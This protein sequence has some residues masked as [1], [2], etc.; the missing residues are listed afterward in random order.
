MSKHAGTQPPFMIKGLIVI[1]AIM[2]C[3]GLP[4][5][6]ETLEIVTEEAKVDPA[7]LERLFEITEMHADLEVAFSLQT[8]EE[9]VSRLPTALKDIKADGTFDK[10]WRKW[11]V[12]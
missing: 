10:I 8:P 5:A 2:A 11:Q 12:R 7:R 4:V 6:A 3:P 9:T 1:T